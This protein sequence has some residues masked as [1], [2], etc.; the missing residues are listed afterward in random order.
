VA[1]S[2]TAIRE[3]LKTSDDT[4]PWL[5]IVRSFNTDDGEDETIDV[6]PDGLEKLSGQH[7]LLGWHLNG[8]VLDF[9]SEVGAEL[10]ADEYG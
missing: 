5:Q 9:L 1:P 4:T 3:L 8:E 2:R 10:D 7:Q 6:T